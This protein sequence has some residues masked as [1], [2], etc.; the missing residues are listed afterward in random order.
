MKAARIAVSPDV[1][2]MLR[3]LRNQLTEDFMEELSSYH[4]EVEIHR[5]KDAQQFASLRDEGQYLR[6]EVL[7][8]QQLL[9]AVKE[10][11]DELRRALQEHQGAV[12]SAIETEVR[13]QFADR[14]R[15]LLSL[16]SALPLPQVHVET[17]APNINVETRTPIVNVETVAPNINVAAPNII[18]P[19][20]AIRVDVKQEPSLVTV[21][22]QIHLP[23]QSPATVTVTP[24]FHPE[25][26]VVLPS[27]RTVT[28]TIEYEDGKPVR[29]I[30]E[31]QGA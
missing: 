24:D 26:N 4:E 6:G 14:N 30:E 20:G 21:N 16:V 11:I 17:V 2:V 31:D 5:E 29:I 22:P 15:E 23:K 25:V 1:A 3:A 13:S 8:I 19:E 7:E 18:L 12:K 10:G 27:R 28:K 9:A